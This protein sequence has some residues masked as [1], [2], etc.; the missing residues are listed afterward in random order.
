M[1]TSALRSVAAA[2]SIEPL[3]GGGVFATTEAGACTT[4]VGADFAI[5]TGADAFGVTRFS[6]VVATTG[7]GGRSS[8]GDEVAVTTAI[9]EDAV[10]AERGVGLGTVANSF[11]NMS[12]STPAAN[13]SASLR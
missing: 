12:R 11:T 3:G 13:A 4:C 9:V 6:V 5:S 2:V 7:A 10:D 8:A 1:F